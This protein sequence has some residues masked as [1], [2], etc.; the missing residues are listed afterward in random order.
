MTKP[1]LNN[2]RRQHY[3]WKKYLE[4]WTLQGRLW[5]LRNGDDE[6]FNTD[7]VN[8]A[9][10]RDFYKLHGLTKDDC[11]FIRKVALD[12]IKNEDLRKLNEGWLDNFEMAF[13]VEQHFRNHERSTEEIH[14]TLDILLNTL[15][16]NAH[17]QLESSAGKYFASLLKGDVTFY[18]S[19]EG[20]RDFS[21]F[22]AH[23]YLRT[24][25]LQENVRRATVND[26]MSLARLQRIWPILRHIYATCISFSLFVERKTMRPTIVR[27]PEGMEFLTCDQPVLNTYGAFLPID[28]EVHKTEFYYPISPSMALIVSDR[29]DYFEMHGCTVDPFRVTYFN[30][31]IELVAHEFVFSQS[32]A[33]LEHVLFSSQPTL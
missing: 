26:Q 20:A 21:F 24:K 22:L 1:S 9:V 16:E 10:E 14:E 2:K 11:N 27:C 28:E 4:P 8:V 25:K 32:K 30:Q 31:M 5:A 7:P 29:I 23:Q 19:E 15:D 18:Q 3:V 13:A 33:T 12:P 17:S 6:P